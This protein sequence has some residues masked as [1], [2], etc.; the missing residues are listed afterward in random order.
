[1]IIHEGNAQSG[2]YYAYIYDFYNKKWRKFNDIRTTDVEE[3]E[4]FKDGNGGESNRSAYWVV[5]LNDEI[6]KE[7]ENNNINCYKY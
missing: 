4:V 2:H 6:K 3:A 5:Y 1:M 7:L